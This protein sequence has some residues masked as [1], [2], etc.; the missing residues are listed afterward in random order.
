MSW[1][2]AV[3]INNNR[4]LIFTSRE[5]AEAEF[6]AHLPAVGVRISSLNIERMDPRDVDPCSWWVERRVKPG[7]DKGKK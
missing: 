7:K 1:V 6:R 2:W 3:K 5:E 4:P